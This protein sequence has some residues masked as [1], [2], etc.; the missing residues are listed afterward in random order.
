MPTTAVFSHWTRP[1]GTGLGFRS[2]AASGISAAL[3]VHCA[4]RWAD[5]V[6]LYTDTPGARQFDAY[7]IAFDAVHTDLDAL[8]PTNVW[9]AGKLLAYQRAALEGPFLHVDF[10]VYTLKPLPARLFRAPLVA[11]SIERTDAPGKWFYRETHGITMPLLRWLPDS[12]K[13][14]EQRPWA[15]RLAF[16]AGV[17]GGMDTQSLHAYATDALALLYR[18]ADVWGKVSGGNASVQVEQL[19]FGAHARYR[20]QT[21]TTLL[22]DEAHTN[23][24]ER[25][26]SHFG[27]VHLY[28]NAKQDPRNVLKLLRRAER[29]LPHRQY[30]RL[31]ALGYWSVDNPG[32]DP[33]IPPGDP[34]E[35]N[36]LNPNPQPGG[37]AANPP[38]VINP[39]VGYVDPS[40]PA[41]PPPSNT[42]ILAFGAGLAAFLFLR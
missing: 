22:T 26:A 20:R 16:N 24:N 10:D 23:V 2:R 28:G 21:V 8:P 18:N 15:S 17:L 19:G 39:G 25:D 5:R 37:G 32:F 27:Y 14:D 30:R 12:W 11:Q 42:G 35:R 38:A 7:G 9:A 1:G 40:R 3:A 41:P 34:V 36:P 31:T 6:V 29:E 13:A 33:M 4:R